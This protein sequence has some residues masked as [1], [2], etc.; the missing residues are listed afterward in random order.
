LTEIWPNYFNPMLSSR[1]SSI[2]EGLAI[3]AFNDGKFNAKT[4]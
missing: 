1:L 3:I 2:V 4:L